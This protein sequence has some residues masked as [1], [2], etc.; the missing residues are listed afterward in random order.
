MPQDWYGHVT[1][2]CNKIQ[3]KIF[4]FHIRNLSINSVVSTLHHKDAQTYVEDVGITASAR[5]N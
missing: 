5:G 1:R 3:T 2:A 4:S